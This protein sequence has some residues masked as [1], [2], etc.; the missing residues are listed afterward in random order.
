MRIRFTWLLG[1]LVLIGFGLLLACGRQY[2]SVANGLVVVSVQSDNVMDTFTLDLNTGAVSQINNVNGPGTPGA[3][4]VVLLDP[5][6]AFAYVLVS[7]NSLLPGTGIVTYPVLSDGKLG[8]ASSST[9][10]KQSGGVPVLPATMVID[11]AGKFIFVA[12]ST[13]GGVP[14]TVSVFAVNS[15]QLTEVSGS[16]FA[17]P[18]GTMGPA[19]LAGLA[20]TH[21]VFP[22]EP[23]QCGEK[24]PP[25]AE[26]LYVTDEENSL[27]WEF[28]VSSAGAL[29][30]PPGDN[31]VMSFG[32]G[33]NP[34]GIT[35]DPCN[36]YAYVSN[37]EDNTI[38]AYTVCYTQVLGT[39]PVADGSLLTVQGSPFA[40]QGI[41]PGPMSE[42]IYGNYLYVVNASN[43]VAGYAISNTGKITQMNPP[44]LG[45]GTDP[46]SIAVRS[47]DN[48]VFVANFGSANVSYFA[49]TPGTGRLT[50]QQPF[51]TDPYP[52]GVAV[53]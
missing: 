11:S 23:A 45:T 40:D 13:N 5:S 31:S 37:S 30:P 39:C 21:T 38:S 44:T 48:W 7:Q 49:I 33:T 28:G 16:P 12:N 6:G 41:T 2:S 42:D 15:G 3:P 27:V 14:G 34:T 22:P 52:F 50:P 46:V 1:L 43:S 24:A 36:R 19:N 53:K 20:L 26:N 35:V 17:V 18:P 29:G 8:S 4:S 25:T 51:Q 32:T 10:F 9:A 47:D